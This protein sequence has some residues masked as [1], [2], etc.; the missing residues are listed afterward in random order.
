MQSSIWETA[1]FECLLGIIILGDNS[2][3]NT[4]LLW[5]DSKY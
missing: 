3:Q 2:F 4:F 5:L 1:F